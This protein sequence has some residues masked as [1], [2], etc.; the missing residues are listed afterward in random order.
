MRT[1]VKSTS[2]AVLLT[3]GFVALGVTAVPASAAFAGTT[4]GDSSVLGGN[5]ANLPI[6]A[7]VNACG[8]SA[9]VL[10]K[11]AAGCE[12]GAAVHK[13]GHKGG[14]KGHKGPKGKHKPGKHKPGKHKG[15]HGR[16]G[17]STSG[18]AG[19][20][21]GNQVNAPVKAPV[22]A[23][24]NAVAVAGKADAG[25]KGGSAAHSGHGK[26][27]GKGHG[28]APGKG[29]GK[30]AQHHSGGKR[31]AGQQTSGK[32]GILAGNQVNAPI[33]IPVN[34]CGNA[35]AILGK[36]V[37]G[38]E[39]GAAVTGGARPGGRQVTSGAFS[40]LG[41]NQVN[42][43]ISVPVNVCGNAVAVLG[44]A[45]AVCEGGAR[46]AG[47][48]GRGGAGQ[49][50]SGAHGVLAG[51]QVNAPISVPVNVC[52][53]AV[54]VAGRAEAGCKGAAVA[55]RP[56]RQRGDAASRGRDGSSARVGRG[57]PGPG[58]LGSLAKLPTLPKTPV[59]VL[60]KLSERSAPA[61]GG[62]SAQGGPGT[63]GLPGAKVLTG[64][65]GVKVPEVGKLGA[66]KPVAAVEPLADTPKA[67]SVW[68]LGMAVVFVSGAFALTRKARPGRR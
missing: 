40:V 61:T 30:G 58:D 25:C 8:N 68:G 27:P 18:K 22:N 32:H 38:C 37:A 34:V 50:T 29:H 53:N 48:H 20:G 14:H 66:I 13:G 35:V 23:C 12:G 9:A 44:K 51:N 41:G 56:G 49:K 60:P 1:W 28:K 5:Q 15:G 63:D 26:A 57:T 54:A 47:G 64:A 6:S 67:G 43:P 65:G 45:G 39:G 19:I 55:G 31:P 62:R 4:N 3:A 7:P 42:A 2:R 59:K 21:S 10:G 52:G 17:Q 16:G 11:A 24:G 36:A 46:V 33:S